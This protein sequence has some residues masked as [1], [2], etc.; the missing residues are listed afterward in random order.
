MGSGAMF[1]GIHA[2]VEKNAAQILGY[3]CDK[4]TF[5]GTTVY[6]IHDVGLPLKTEAN[7]MGMQMVMEATKIN[8]G[9]S[10]KKYFSHPPGITPVM[11]PQADAMA[12][13]MAQQTM[14]MLKDPEAAKNAS[15][16]RPMMG[17]PNQQPQQPQ[18]TPEEQ[19]QMEQA[20]EALKNIFGN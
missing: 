4:M 2:E 19:Q 17:N 7:M 3:D 10:P 9:S 20:M 12:R 8:K 5:M 13:S 15:G 6:A 1:V 11:D 18:M 16:N 14:N